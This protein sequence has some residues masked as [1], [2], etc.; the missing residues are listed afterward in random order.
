MAA[1]RAIASIEGAWGVPK[2][3]H[4]AAAVG[5][6]LF[7]KGAPHVREDDGHGAPQWKSFQADRSMRVCLT[8]FK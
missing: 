3:G 1:C 6:W 4:Y 2:G 8:T 7:A 5:A